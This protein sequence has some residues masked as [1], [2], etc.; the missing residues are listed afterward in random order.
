MSRYPRM[1]TPPILSSRWLAAMT[2]VALLCGALFAGGVALAE[3]RAFFDRPAVYEGDTVTLIIEADGL[4]GQRQPDLT[5]LAEDFE[6]LGT[7]TGS[8]IRI[9]N[10]RRS[11]KVSWRVS[12]V[13][14]RLGEIRVPPIGI[15]G[16]QT[17]PLTLTVAEVPEG[18][19]AGPGD[20]VFVEL[21]LG[22]EGDSVLVQQQVPVV[23][24]LLS[25]L[26]IRGGELSDPRA[27]GAVLERLGADRQ[28]STERNGREYEV[29]E[30]RFSL[31]PERSG[32]LR[33][34]PVVFDGE[35]RSPRPERGPFDHEPRTGMF[36]D[37]MFEQ[38][39]GEGPLSMFERGQ[40]VRAHSRAVTLQVQARP[41]SFGGA[42]W[43]P[44]EALAIDDSWAREPPIL[45][46]GEPATRTLTVTARGLAGSQIPRI[47][48]PLPPGLRAY[49]EQ[50]EA[51]S[52]TDGATLFGVSVQP[53][54]VIPTKGGQIEVP[55]I[56]VSWWDTAA[57]QERVTTVP[58]LIIDVEGPAVAAA[59]P[60]P[61]DAERAKPNTPPPETA[62]I[63][64][65]E[66][67]PETTGEGDAST[68]GTGV[69]WRIWGV[70]GLLVATLAAAAAVIWRRRATG[71]A[72]VLGA[73]QPAARQIDVGARREAL[74]QACQAN[75][76]SAAAR[77]LLAWAQARWSDSTT[78]SGAAVLP[79]NLAAVAERLAA[80]GS[81]AGAQAAERVS[82]LERRLYAPDDESWQ[83]EPLWLAIKDVLGGERAEGTGTGRGENDDLAPLYPS[84]V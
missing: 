11:D 83:G 6:M 70:A 79:V 12:L 35:L 8:E 13:P 48:V 55:E 29:I 28:Y 62:A 63:S 44:A 1:Q 73:R 18:G 80:S 17:K 39:F 20:D 10:G 68:L 61:S 24:R 45:R 5:V 42:H 3:P 41:D 72:S 37:P 23:V 30:R 60:Q 43:L 22:I 81:A 71:A 77:A 38:F 2:G 59:P 69:N 67:Q 66:S 56:R 74:R 84:R 7:S 76:P 21:E 50:A 31:S 51:E 16:E 75:D 14:K 40:P 27:D 47:D 54:T 34:A 36:R 46:A 32:E 33:I 25:A 57:E 65:P 26:P 53:L 82:L 4:S 64:K 49:P 78:P 15:G 9:V 58:S 19:G 52:R